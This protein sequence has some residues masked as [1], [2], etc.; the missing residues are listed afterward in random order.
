[1]PKHLTNILITLALVTFIANPVLA[2]DN[3]PQPPNAKDRC[4]VC[5][6]FVAKYPQWFTLLVL[7]NGD[8]VWFDGVKD[9]MV[10]H[11]APAKFG[12]PEDAS[13]TMVLV[14]DYYSQEWIDGE[15]AMYVVGSDVYGPMGHELIPFSS[16]KAAKTFA[17]DH[18]GK[19]IL[20][21]AEIKPDRIESMRMGHKMKKMQEH[22]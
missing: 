12:K 7:D 9:M 10:Y 11:F 18:H 22:K 15:K 21:F 2:V 16:E 14:K 8:K 4:A 17:K 5:G 1:M 13:I 20:H 3:A 6:M 19:E